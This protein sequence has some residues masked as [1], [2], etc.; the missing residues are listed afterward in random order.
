MAIVGSRGFQFGL[1]LGAAVTVLMWPH[2]S[3]A[4]TSEQQQACT[5]DAM[6]LCSAY[7]PDVDSIT[8]C[9][10]RNKSQLSPTCRVFFRPGRETGDAVDASAHEQGARQILNQDRHQSRDR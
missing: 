5:P 6:R 8:A 2:T 1:L 4:F 7:I 3:S 10:I 9:M